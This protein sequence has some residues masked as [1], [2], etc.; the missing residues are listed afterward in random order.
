MRQV[1]YV[2]L[3]ATSN[4]FLSF[5]AL[6]NAPGKERNEQS[7]WPEEKLVESHVSKTAKRGP[8]V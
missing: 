2:T 4:L 1:S 8:S 3:L 7:P 5:H 6:T